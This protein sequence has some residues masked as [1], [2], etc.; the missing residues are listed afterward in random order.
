MR[1][2]CDWRTCVLHNFDIFDS[3]LSRLLFSRICVASMSKR[4]R[5]RRDEIHPVSESW[6]VVAA[7]RRCRESYCSQWCTPSTVMCDLRV[8]VGGVEQRSGMSAA[9]AYHERWSFDFMQLA[10]TSMRHI[11]F[12]RSFSPH[13]RNRI[14]MRLFC[15]FFATGSRSRIFTFS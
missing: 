3:F 11:V 13:Q 2:A 9:C 10:D 1:G 5:C 8:P 4:V 15:I 12:S 14:G 7:G 6:R